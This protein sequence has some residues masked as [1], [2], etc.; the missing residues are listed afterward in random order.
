VTGG[1]HGIGR[2]RSSESLCMSA[3]RYLFAAGK[4]VS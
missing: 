1:G 4:E 3:S 2:A